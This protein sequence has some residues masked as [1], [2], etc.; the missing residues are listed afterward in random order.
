MVGRSGIYELE[1]DSNT[2]IY[3]LTFDTKSLQI[4]DSSSQG[5]LIIDVIYDNKEV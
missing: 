2:E 1:L 5:Y 3:N 4:I